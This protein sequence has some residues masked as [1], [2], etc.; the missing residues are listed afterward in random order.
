M[1]IHPGSLR[2]SFQFPR[3]LGCTSLAA[4]ITWNLHW[5]ALKK[6]PPSIAIGVFH[7]PAPT[8]GMTRSFFCFLKGDFFTSLKWNPFTIPLILLLAWSLLSLIKQVV[9]KEKLNLNRVQ[10]TAWLFILVTAWL[11]KL[12]QSPA[13]W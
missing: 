12:I 3:L 2:K 10:V 11:F 4:Y 13:W 7:I 1:Q 9:K 8:T 5:L 6:I